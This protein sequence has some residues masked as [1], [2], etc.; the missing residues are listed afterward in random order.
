VTFVDGLLRVDEESASVE[1]EVTDLHPETPWGK[2][3]D[4][5]AHG[6]VE[7]SCRMTGVVRVGGREVR[8]DGAL[9]HRDRSWGPRDLEMCVNHRWLAGTC[10]PE[11]CFSLDNLVVSNGSALELGYVV[12]DG[13]AD[14]VRSCEIVVG[15]ATD[16][17]TPR[18]V[19]AVAT[20]ESGAELTVR[21]TSAHRTFLDVRQGWF[22][23]TDT[24]FEV[25]AEGRTGIADLNLTV[26]PQQGRHVPLLVVR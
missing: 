14:P 13:E 22:T 1:V 11:L 12:R 8:L 9:G 7:T 10:G 23:A 18:F 2:P 17:L 3:V 25:E 21:T 5:L 6:H 24:L 26:N 15:L 19:E 20:C 16:C 4:G